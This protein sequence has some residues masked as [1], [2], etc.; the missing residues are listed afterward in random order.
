MRKTFFTSDLHFCDDRLNL[1]GRELIFRN[2]EEV[3]KCIIENWNRFVKDD[4]LVVVVGDV[5]LSER[6][7]QKMDLLKGEKY[8]IKGNYDVP[9]TAKYPVTD[10]ML[11]KYFTV[12]KD[13]LVMSIGGE[14]VYINHYPEKCSDKMFNICGHIHEKWKAQR[15]AINVGTDAWHFVPVSEDQIKFQMN[16]IRKHYDQNVF[17]GELLSN[18]KNRV[19]KIKVLEPPTYDNCATFEEDEDIVI[20]LMGPIQGTYNWQNDFVEKFKKILE[21]KKLTK[22][23]II[24]NPKRKVFVKSEFNYGEQVDWESFYLDKAS[25]QGAIFCWLARETEKVKGRQYSQTTRFELGEWFAKGQKIE[26]FKMIVGQ[27]K[28]YEGTRYVEYKFKQI[29]PEFKMTYDFDETVK[30]LIEMLKI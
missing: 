16:A 29:C 25:K 7:L 4:D 1:F 13:D 18:V 5:S 15:N 10:E 2:S 9:E 26:N 22:N 8:L 27:D 28:E 3:D 12:V 21:G 14:F 6:G 19:G 11:K 20:F 17:A 30:E 24:A 23:I